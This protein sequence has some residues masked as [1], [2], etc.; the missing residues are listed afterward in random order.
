MSGCKSK[1][2]SFYVVSLSEQRR[3]FLFLPHMPKIQ[4]VTVNIY[5]CTLIWVLLFQRTYYTLSQYCKDTTYRLCHIT[6]FE[7]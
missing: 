6:V 7:V 1:V 5:C 2:A 3:C 4:P